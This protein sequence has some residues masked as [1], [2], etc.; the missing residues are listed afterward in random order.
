MLNGLGGHDHTSWWLGAIL[1]S[2]GITSGN[3]P[4][5]I[6][7]S[8]EF[9]PSIAVCKANTVSP[10]LPLQP[11]YSLSCDYGI[12]V[13]KKIL[14]N[15]SWGD[16]RVDRAFDL[17]VANLGLISAP[18]IV[19]HAPPGVIPESRTRNKSWAPLGLDLPYG[20][21]K[22]IK[23]KKQWILTYFYEELYS[24]FDY[25]WCSKNY[26]VELPFRDYLD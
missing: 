22:K 18:H 16:S 8:R 6:N 14:Q 9:K 17:N 20:Q 1:L 24:N 7:G 2:S 19:P 21:N 25:L 3:A 13:K 11:W 10:L 15:G 23:I 5:I 4:G 26:F 12:L